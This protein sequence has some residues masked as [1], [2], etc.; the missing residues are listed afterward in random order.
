MI[1][2]CPVTVND[3][4]V[5]EDIFG[6]SIHA[7]KGK[8]TRK[9]PPKV[10]IDIIQVPKEILKLHNN[11]ILKMD[12]MYVNGLPFLLTVSSKIKFITVE[13]LPGKQQQKHY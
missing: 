4:E 5:A 13:Y 6:K 11:V 1:Y 3:I 12:I 7:L 2:N 8:T 9:S 10:E